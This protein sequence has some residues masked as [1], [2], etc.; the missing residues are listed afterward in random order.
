MR[1]NIDWLP[2]A[3][4]SLGIEPDQESNQ[5]PLGAWVDVQ[6]LSNTGWAN[7]TIIFWSA[8]SLNLPISPM[9]M[10]HPPS[11]L[12]QTSQISVFNHVTPPFPGHLLHCPHI[13]LVG[14]QSAKILP[15]EDMG[16]YSFTF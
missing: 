5:Q 2:P 10:V 3:C 12:P 1:K 6:T 13:L 11:C 7:L 4:P 9:V 16:I 8:A 15:G 14:N